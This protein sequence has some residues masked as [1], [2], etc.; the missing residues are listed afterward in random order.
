MLSNVCG[1]LLTLMVVRVHENP[2]DQIVPVLIASNID[3]WNSRTIWVCGC[4]NTKVPI[5]KLRTTNLQ[6]LLH[7]LGRKLIDA[8]AVGIG[9]DV[10]DDSA[11][12]WG[13]TMFA[14]MLNAPISELTMSDKIDACGDFFDCRTLGWGQLMEMH[15]KNCCHLFLFD[16]VFKDVLHDKTACLSKSNLVPHASKSFV[17]LGHDLWRLTTPS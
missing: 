5:K 8:V 17:H 13:R 6:A 3:Q 16:T 11:L 15:P 9:K 7:D 14:K 12:V 1:D 2:L 4:D 10:V